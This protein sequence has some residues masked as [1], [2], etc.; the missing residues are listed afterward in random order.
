GS[1]ILGSDSVEHDAERLEAPCE[2]VSHYGGKA[3][4]RN[5][6]VVTRF[7]LDRGSEPRF[8]QLLR[9]DQ[10]RREWLLGE[11]ALPALFGPARPSQV[12]AYDAVDVDALGA[13]DHQRSTAQ[14]G[15]VPLRNEMV[16]YDAGG[17]LE[18]ELR[19]RRQHRALAWNRLV[20]HH[21]ESGYPIGGD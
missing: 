5:V 7:C 21:V 8:R 16:R 18:P 19:Q 11:R 12:P 20:H 13:P 3:R 15:I 10:P 9:F 14:R 1:G 2:I 4:A 6:L 17:P